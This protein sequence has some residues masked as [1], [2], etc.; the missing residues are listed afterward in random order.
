[1]TGLM[2]A[3]LSRGVI[4][5]AP[6]SCVIEDVLPE[7]I[8][9]GVEIF[10]ATTVRGKRTMLGAGTKLGLAGGGYFE[11]VRTG[12]NVQLWGGYFKDC[13]LLDNVVVRS[14]AE[15]RECTLLEESSELGHTVGLKQTIVMP[16]C[17]MGSLINFCDALLSGGLSRECHTEVGS[18]MALYNYTPWGNKFAS[19]FGDVPRGVFL[20]EEPIFIGGQTQIVSPVVV[21]YESV[22]AAGCKL[23]TNL[24]PRQ[25]VLYSPQ[26]LERDFNR[27]QLPKVQRKV[28]IAFQY[29]ANLYA[30]RVWY[31]IARRAYASSDPYLQQLYEDVIGLIDGAIAERRKRLEK[32]ITKIR[33]SLKHHESEFEVILVHDH[34][35]ALEFCKRKMPKL[36][37]KPDI[38]Q[39]KWKTVVEYLKK[40]GEEKKS[41]IEAVRAMPDDMVDE[42]RDELYRI[43]DQ[44]A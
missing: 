34:Q 27:E 12:R 18:C 39:K 20:C 1:M 21:D 15:L 31:D 41:Y 5:H 6:E 19:L 7:R 16:Q 13:I 25:I 33:V 30:F 26:D 22:I 4:I 9:A 37:V 38:R 44:Y 35:V 40:A 14:N 36:D 17:I 42:V 32:F 23:Q 28:E 10:P 29:I 8:E 24:G 2:Q 3:L 43:V 11:D